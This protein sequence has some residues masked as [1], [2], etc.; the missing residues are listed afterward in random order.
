MNLG[1]WR[2][3]VGL[4]ALA[5]ICLVGPVLAQTAASIP[6]PALKVNG[7]PISRD[8]LLDRLV[9]YHGVFVLENLIGEKLF[10]A[11][12]KKR[13]ITV[14]EQ[15]IT[16]RVNAF[17]KRIGAQADGAFSSW[18][19]QNEITENFVRNQQRI[20]IMVE[21]TFGPEANVT[22]A[23]V[24]GVYNKYKARYTVPESVTFL[25]LVTLT[26]ELAQKALQMI[27]SGKD[28]PTTAKELG[29]SLANAAGPLTFALKD[30]VIP[31]QR[32]ALE[33]AAV[34]QLVGPLKVPLD[35]QDPNSPA[36][37]YQIM[38]VVS[39]EAG[40]NRPFAEVKDEIRQEILEDRLFG[41]I[42][43]VNTWMKKEMDKAVIERFVTFKGEPVPGK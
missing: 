18:L 37:R 30:I 39:R 20:K 16:D 4:F 12:A 28:F 23:E 19:S 24:E 29:P 9:A 36:I 21:K 34:G 32:A 41:P 27:K 7:Q 40:R 26:D 43:I 15:E 10:E 8:L 3:A 2:K 17:R 5:G 31:A 6:D 38:K 33:K 22:D 13:G 42:G 25:V 35:P 14:S 1:N 11:E